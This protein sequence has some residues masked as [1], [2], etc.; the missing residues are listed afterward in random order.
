LI[1]VRRHVAILAA[2]TQGHLNPLQVLG[3]ELARRGCK[4]TVVHVAGARRFVTHPAIDF[5]PLSGRAGGHASLDAFLARLADPTG[6]VGTARMI[7]ATAAL[8]DTLLD[9]APAVLERIGADAVVADM[10][11]PAGALIAERLGLPCIATVTGLPLLS[12]AEVPPPFLGWRYRPDALGRFRNRGGYAVS[13]WLMRPVARV[14]DEHRRRWRLN[15]PAPAPTLQV[16]QC[17]R[18]LDYPRIELPPGF[19]Y[20]SPWRD[21]G[22]EDALLPADDGRPLVFCSLG[23]LQGARWGLFAKMSAA[24]AALGARA[25]IGHGGALT[26]AEEAALPGDPLVRAYWPQRAVLRR[27]S[28]AV[29]HGGFNTV[30][31]ALAAGVPIVAVP[32]AFEQPA[33]AAR[34]AWVGAGRVL[35]PRMLSVAALRDALD[36]VMRRP[37]YRRAAR[38]IGA[39]MESAGGVACAAEAIGLALGLE[40]RRASQGATA[41]AGTAS[42]SPPSTSTA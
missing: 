6:P 31:D 11:E 10:V 2:P 30:L 13:D 39:E 28:A 18:G 5:A 40:R 24:C 37:S 16:A 38:R 17:P 7:R 3:A 25:V 9:E 1:P 21:D 19:R 27:C 41:M 33:I 8:S 15:G 36:A 42:A 14:L 23:T 22:D 34:I 29:L 26:G 4:V 35:P 12:E 32:I 20:G